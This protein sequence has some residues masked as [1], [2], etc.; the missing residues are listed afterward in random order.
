MGLKTADEYR[1]S[2]NDGRVV[3]WGGEKI[4]DVTPV[5]I[6]GEQSF[7]DGGA[8]T[9]SIVAKEPSTV[10]RMSRQAFEYLRREHAD[11]ACAFLY[12]IARSLAQRMRA[13]T[14]RRF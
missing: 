3:Y 2:L 11:V 6:I 5:A 13:A 10:Y 7:L 14:T 1:A 9:A 4:T 8:R 12:D